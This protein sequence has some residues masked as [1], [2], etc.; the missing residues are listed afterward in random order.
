VIIDE[1]EPLPD[2]TTNYRT[3]SLKYLETLKAIDSFI[4][5]SRDARLAWVVIAMTFNLT[6]VRGWTLPAIADAI[7][8][9]E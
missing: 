6:S 7:G 5:S 4:V 3:A 2:E 1:I 8:V 9:P